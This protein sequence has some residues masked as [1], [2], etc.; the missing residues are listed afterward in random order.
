[1][2][3]L[4]GRTAFVT[5]G[6]NGV[7]LGLARALLAEGCKVAIADV[8]EDSIEAALKLLE[9]QH[10]IGVPLDVASRESFAQA[11]DRVEAELGPVSLL[12][13]NAGVNLFQTID[14]SSYDDW[15]WLLG[16]NLHGVING[17]TTF[18]P[19]MK[20][21]GLGGHVC[22]TASMAAF[23][24]NGAPGIYNT[25]KFA[26]RGLSESLRY[27]LAAHGIGVSMLCPGLVK[28]QIYASDA[29]RPEAL[30]A[31]AKEINTEFVSNLEKLHEAG[32]EPEVIAARTLEA[33]Q[34]NRFYI[35][36]HP[37]FKDELAEVFDEVLADFREY[38]KDP[39]LADRL[40]IEAG[41]RASY[42]KAREAAN[43]L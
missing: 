11:A 10:V 21:R 43:A 6:A 35:F 30:K 12:F 29:I 19:R 8:R 18:V 4:A 5:G 22:N 24:C 3:Q 28:S 42:K 36:S 1:M 26:V 40:Q 38:P 13:N 33:I 20:E 39:G 34:E 14:D 27:S 32:M 16:V 37:E 2:T 9:N 17:V 31:G 41:R 23:L 15:D 25:T 7:G